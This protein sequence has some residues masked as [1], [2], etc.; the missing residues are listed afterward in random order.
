MNKHYYR[1]TATT[2][3]GGTNSEAY[4]VFDEEPTEEELAEFADE[5]CL[6]NAE[7][8]EYLVYGWGENPVESGEMTQE[9][10]DETMENYYADCQCTWEEI[11]EEEYNEN[12]I[13]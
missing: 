13:H 12:T 9:E 6:N 11:S 1:F 8:Y 3:Y 5:F 2:P 10:F 7:G 4:E